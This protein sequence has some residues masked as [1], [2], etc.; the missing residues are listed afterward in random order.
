MIAAVSPAPP[1]LWLASASPARAALLGNAGIE[2]RTEAA[3]VDEGEIKAA[4][5][6][7]GGGAA[8]AA[9]TLAELKAMRVSR[10][11]PG[12]LVVGADQMLACEGAWY[13]KPV[14]L[15]DARRQLRALR[16][17]CHELVTAV[18]VVRDGT[19][20]WH[21]VERA[22]LWMRDFSE[23]FLDGYLKAEGGEAPELVGAYRLEGRGAQ[24]FARVEG[25][26]FGILGLPLLPL[27]DFL[28]GQGLART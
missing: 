21:H 5:R 25:D 3:G 1:R 8:E 28:R 18:C 15:G 11:H 6:A 17:K 2:A 19:R 12:A 20:L 23:E 4:L 16:G 24:L 7:Q 22:R 10:R 14:D 27:L 9:E 13:D 26:F